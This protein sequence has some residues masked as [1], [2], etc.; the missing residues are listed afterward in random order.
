[1]NVDRDSF[2]DLD[3]LYQQVILDH[4]RN[5]RNFH[6]MANPDGR[7]EGY[8]PLCGDRLTVELKA[9]HQTVQDIAFTGKACAICTS[10]A[11]MMTQIVK[12][13][14]LDQVMRIFDRFHAMLTSKTG[15]PDEAVLDKLVVFAGVKKYPIRVR[16]RDFAALA[17]AQSG[18]TDHRNDP[19]ST[20]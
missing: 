2:G 10:S 3:E 17:H 5:P 6:P 7:A 16:M 15:E 9:D 20:E 18:G 14:P 4:S 12:G 11:S 8:N 1:M 19:V 13:K